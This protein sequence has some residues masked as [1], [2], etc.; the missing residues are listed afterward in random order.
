MEYGK[1]RIVNEGMGN[2]YVIKPLGRG[3]IPKEL[4]GRYTSWGAAKQAIDLYEGSK[5]N[6][7]TGSTG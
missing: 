6:G 7:K 2:M 3:A 5:N 4:R 1:Y